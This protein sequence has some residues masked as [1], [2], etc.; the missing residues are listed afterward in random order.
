M[1]SSSSRTAQKNCQ[2]SEQLVFSVML[3]WLGYY[4]YRCLFVEHA[5]PLDV[6][7]EWDLVRVHGVDVGA[8]AIALRQVV[9]TG[10]IRRV[11]QNNN[12]NRFPYQTH[13]PFHSRMRRPSRRLPYIAPAPAVC[14]APESQRP[15]APSLCLWSTFELKLGTFL[16]QSAMSCS[17]CM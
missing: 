7:F 12:S 8:H 16:Q 13:S 14:L 3:S 6:V 5:V 10:Q 9:E 15:A 2:A 4:T 11:L 1:T 17:S